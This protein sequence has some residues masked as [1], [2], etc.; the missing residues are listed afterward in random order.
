MNKIILS[1]SAIDNFKACNI[2]W[3]N[4]QLYRLR[5]IEKSDSLRRGTT[6]HKIQELVGDMDA[7]TNY[8][9]EQY[10][11]VPLNKT[12][13]EWEI[14]RIILLY[15]M[16]G[17]NWYYD[18]QP[19]NYKI[20]ATE[21]EFKIPFDN[22]I[23]LGKIDQLVQDEYENIYIREFKSSSKSLD[24]TYWD[25]LNLDDQVSMYILAVNWLR[26]NGKLE[27]YGISK[28]TPMITGVLY[29]VWHKPGIGPKFITQKVSKELV[30]TGKYCDAEFEIS[31]WADPEQ[32]L[33]SAKIEVNNV[34]AITK[35]GKK[36]GTYT[37][38]ETPEMFGAR[39]LQDIVERPEYYFQEKELTR[40][41]D[42]ME[43]FQNELKSIYEAM[44]FQAENELWY[45]CSK[46]CRSR[47]KCQYVDLCEHHKEIDFDNPPEGFHF[48]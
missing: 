39:L 47:F 1:A 25:H 11:T 20:I 21:V 24:D 44:K 38:Y 32:F 19:T 31:Y 26:I 46:E 42:E 18:Q 27:E 40:T 2:R 3:R 23:L 48:I 9:N 14:E 8:I 37:I 6:W 5:Q 33:Q 13:E 10:E 15:S 22:T 28:D 45:P 36:E 30:E 35:P 4:S 34:L 43:N 29:N 12:K 7:I 16:A 41:S 17:Y